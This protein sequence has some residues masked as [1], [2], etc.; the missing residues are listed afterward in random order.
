MKKILVL[1]V[2]LSGM[3]SV[4]VAQEPVRTNTAEPVKLTEAEMDSVAGGQLVDVI[5]VD[6]V[7]VERNNVAVSANVPVSAAVAAFGSGAGS[8]VTQ[9][10][11][12]RVRQG[13]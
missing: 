3:A 9:D 7:D 1:A 5:L 11:P 12:G 2:A 8:I 13:Q 10:R 6:V 4:A